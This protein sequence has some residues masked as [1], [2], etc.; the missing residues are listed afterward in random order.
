MTAPRLEEAIFEFLSAVHVLK[1]LQMQD[2][3]LGWRGLE[4]MIQ[5]MAALKYQL[6]STFQPPCL[7]GVGA[8]GAAGK[9]KHGIDMVDSGVPPINHETLLTSLQ[10]LFTLPLWFTFVLLCFARSVVYC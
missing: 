10:L 5:Q 4:P 9:H 3:A 2:L 6:P 1:N 7:I 8:N